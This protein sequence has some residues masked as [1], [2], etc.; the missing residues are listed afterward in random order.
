MKRRVIQTFIVL[1]FGSILCVAPL[2]ANNNLEPNKQTETL[3][4]VN[5]EQIIETEI[6]IEQNANSIV[7]TGNDIQQNEIDIVSEKIFEAQQRINAL[8]CEDTM[9]WFKNTK[10]SKMNI[11]NG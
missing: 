10:K 6:S 11:Q 8:E 5:T 4:T 1:C 7:S 3:L 9:E 2:G